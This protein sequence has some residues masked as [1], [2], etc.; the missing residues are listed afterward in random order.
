[1]PEKIIKERMHESLVKFMMEKQIG[2]RKN[3]L[4]RKIFLITENIRNWLM[5]R[6]PIYSLASGSIVNFNLF[7]S[8]YVNVFLKINFESKIPLK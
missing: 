4:K 2:I 1:M 3:T 7:N 8:E 6:N 5:K